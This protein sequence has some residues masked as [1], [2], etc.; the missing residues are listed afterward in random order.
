MTYG[1]HVLDH[2]SSRSGR[3]LRGKRFRV[4]LWIAAIEGL[5]YVVHVLHWWEAVGLAA[6]GVLFWWYAG[7][8]SRADLVRQV[9][10]VF[11]V[12]QLLVLCVPIALAVVTAFAIGIVVLLAIA[13]LIFLFTE[14][15]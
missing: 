12:S 3:W 4:T 5:L 1:G 11:A 8:N 10:W 2:G 7:R 9:S 6:I 13:A 15:P 14:R